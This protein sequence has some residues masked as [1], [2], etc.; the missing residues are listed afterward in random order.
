MQRPYTGDEYSEMVARLRA[1]VPEITFSTDYIVGFPTETGAD[2][3]LTMDNLRANRPLKVNITRFS[4]RPGTP[5]SSMPDVLERTKKER[6]RLLTA[7]HHEVTSHYMRGAVGSRR[8]VL[9]SEQGKPGTVI[10]RDS[11]YNMVVLL[12]DLPPGTIADVEI[13]AA[14]TTYMIA[15]RT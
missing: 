1:G 13:S 2:F 8:T 14:K 5:A 3:H 11:S 15:R 9:V 6:S 10:A 4:P 12:E 7:L